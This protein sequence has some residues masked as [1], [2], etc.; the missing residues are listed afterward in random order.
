MRIITLTPLTTRQITHS[1]NTA[2]VLAKFG[3]VGNHNATLIKEARKMRI[4]EFCNKP[5]PEWLKLKN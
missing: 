1:N 5:M 4:I 3:N 2:H